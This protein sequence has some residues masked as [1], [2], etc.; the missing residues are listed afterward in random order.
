MGRTDLQKL[1]VLAPVYVRSA[2]IELQRPNKSQVLPYVHFGRKAPPRYARALLQCST[3]TE[4]YLA[5]ILVGPLPVSE[6]RTQWQALDFSWTRKSG[7]RVRDLRVDKK[8]TTYQNWLHEIGRS[9]SDI[10]IFLLNGTATGAADES[11]HIVPT[12]PLGQK[13]DGR[14]VTWYTFR[15]VSSTRFDSSTLLSTGLYFEADVT[16]R[17]PVSWKVLSWFYDDDV[18]STAQELRDACFSESFSKLGMNFNSD[19]VGTDA[20][21]PP[22]PLD[23][24]TP[25]IGLSALRYSLDT[26]EGSMSWMGF[27]FLLGFSQETGLGLFDL[28]YKGLPLIHELS[29]QE[30]LAHYAGHDPFQSNSAPLDSTD[31]FGTHAFE[32]VPGYDCPIGSSYLNATYFHGGKSLIH[33][34]A[35][36]VFEATDDAPLQRHTASGYVTASKKIY[37]TLRWCSTMGD[38]DFIF[39]YRFFMDGTIEID[40]QATGYIIGAHYAHNENYGFHIHDFF[41]GSMHDHVMNWK[42]DFDVLGTANSVQ[43]VKIAASTESFPWSQGVPRNTMRLERS[44]VKTEDDGRWNWSLND[45]TMFTVVN[46]DN[47]SEYGE[48][49]GYRVQRSAGATHLTILNSSVL[50]NAARWAEHDIHVTMQ[51]DY[52]SRSAHPYNNQDIHNPPIDFASFLDGENLD[53]VDLVLWVN[54]GMHHVPTT[55]DLPNTVTT[56]G[57]SSIRLTPHNLFPLDQSAHSISRVRIDYNQEGVTEINTF[58]QEARN[59]CTT[60]VDPDQAQL[61]Q[62]HGIFGARP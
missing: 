2:S 29:L 6:H 49:R 30:G 12:D 1:K 51:H 34:N 11:L 14:I 32:L 17:D 60:I 27:D 25:P 19:W 40:V 16:G 35:I 4:P 26:E 61:L 21:Q 42:V 38:Y 18:Y 53:Q 23:H 8:S 37:L 50:A 44:F 13:E 15:G 54:L 20:H 52:Q 43:L 7:G 55:G 22:L 58:G 45:D 3:T 28:R 36:C 47:K 56:N 5:E 62:Y 10:T 46:R 33:K 31:G 39:S 59:G 57:H 41:S 24:L 9:V 48:E